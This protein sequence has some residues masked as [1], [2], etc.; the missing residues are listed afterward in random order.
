MAGVLSSSRG[1]SEEFLSMTGSSH[2]QS[3]INTEV[4]DILEDNRTYRPY[5]EYN[6]SWSEKGT[7]HRKRQRTHHE[8]H[9]SPRA[10]G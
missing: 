7:N 3:Q 4:M 1:S 8:R 9:R 5:D 10:P 6:L 2:Y